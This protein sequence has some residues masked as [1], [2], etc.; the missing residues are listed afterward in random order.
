MTVGLPAPAHLAL[1][2][3]GDQ[4]LI[5]MQELLHLQRI[6]SERFRCRVD[7]GE[8]A[9]DH[10]HRQ[11]KLHVGDGIRLGRAGELQR[12]QEIGRLTDAARERI[13]HVDKGRPPRAGAER[14]VIEAHRE[15]ILDR[16][17]AAEAY[18]AEEGECGTTL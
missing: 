5:A 3:L 1:A 9:A 11:A 6:I 18:P 7:G 17:G 12:H 4:R 8:A 14:D 13:G 15:R 2:T 16:D 10:H